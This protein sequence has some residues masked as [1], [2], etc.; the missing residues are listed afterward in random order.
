MSDTS[1]NQAAEPVPEGAASATE[2]AAQNTADRPV[3]ASEALKDDLAP[4]EPLSGTARYFSLA[5]GL[6]FATLGCLP[7][8][9]V[10]L[11]GASRQ[12]ALA[13]FGLAAM[14]FIA[15]VLPSHYALRCTL[16]VVAGLSCVLLGT[17]GLGPAAALE[18]I[19][20]EWGLLHW[21]AAAV[22]PAALLFRA[23]YRTFRGTRQLLVAALLLTVPF[24]A[25]AGLRIVVATCLPIQVGYGVSIGAVLLCM[26]GFMGAES[27]GSGDTMAVVATTAITI[28]LA[29][30]VVFDPAGNLHWD[31]AL[32][33]LVSA[34]AFGAAA[35]LGSLG[36]FG[37]LAWRFG[38]L[39]RAVDPR[40]RPP[41]DR[42]PKPQGSGA[43]SPSI[44]GWLGRR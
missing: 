12:Q 7:Y 31:D 35:T 8:F 2:Q 16:M 3:L 1:P 9:G 27:T 13:H 43:P 15:G 37:L 6:S 41:S 25:F 36:T 34:A 33:P 32:R 39:A 38:P 26:L 18:E 30:V 22:L 44:G 14:A 42:N 4:V 5:I 17:V 10:D 28:A 24:V 21:L 19:V 11:A 29:V 40:D 23:R 20:G